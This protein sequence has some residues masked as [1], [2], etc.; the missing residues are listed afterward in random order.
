MAEV[1]EKGM[2]SALA[3]GLKATPGVDAR[4]Q[5]G[6]A[7][8]LTELAKP[9]VT[10]ADAERRVKAWLDAAPGHAVTVLRSVVLAAASQ[11]R[12]APDAWLYRA[13]V[14]GPGKAAPGKAG[15]RPR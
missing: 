8:L 4:V 10:E 11:K 13:F 9:G 3:N 12:V 2:A 5:E 6:F 7:G 14:G 1:L 15:A